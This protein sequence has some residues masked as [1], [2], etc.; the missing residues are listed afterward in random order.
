MKPLPTF[1]AHYNLL[2]CL[3]LIKWHSA[4]AAYCY[5]VNFRWLCNGSTD[6]CSWEC[7]HFTIVDAGQEEAPHV[8][9]T[10]NAGSWVT[11]MTGVSPSFRVG[12]SFEA[13]SLR[14]I[15]KWVLVAD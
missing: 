5:F 9:L 11:V 4:C 3:L 7:L 12:V 15:L 6:S 8:Q 14:L 2:A 1:V 13:I 10:V